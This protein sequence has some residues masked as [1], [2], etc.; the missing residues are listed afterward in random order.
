M[1]K[2]L[3]DNEVKSLSLEITAGFGITPRKLKVSLNLANV[4]DSD[5]VLKF[6]TIGVNVKKNIQLFSETPV[7]PDELLGVVDQYDHWIIVASDGSR[8]AIAQRNKV[9][10]QATKMATQIGY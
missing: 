8:T 5:L 4:K 1:Y 3:N 2:A 10:Q 6:R 7:D 9:R